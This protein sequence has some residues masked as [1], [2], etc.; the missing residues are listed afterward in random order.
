MSDTDGVQVV[1]FVCAC[2]TLR[3]AARVLT[4]MYE[5]C[6][7]AVDLSS[8][9]MTVLMTL[10]RRGPLALSQ[11]AD[12]LAMDRT[13][14]YRAL[15]PLEKRGLVRI[16]ATADRRSKEALL[17][18][19]GERHLVRAK[20]HWRRAQTKFLEKYGEHEWE[21]LHRSLDGVVASVRDVV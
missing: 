16:R 7:A 11:L 17:T 20:P 6:L 21:R 18:V 2:A 4:R 19:D 14:L 15:R 13:S 8:T 10:G 5:E 9:Q 1:G 3:R 12:L